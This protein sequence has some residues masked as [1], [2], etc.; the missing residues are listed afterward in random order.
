MPVYPYIPNSVPEIRDEMLSEIGVPDIESLYREIPAAL[1]LGRPLDLPPA[2][3]SEYDLKKHVEALLAENTTC[4]EYVSFL[5]AGCYRHFV[6]AVCD[7]INARGEFLTAYAG[8]TYSDHGKHQAWFEFQSLLAEL[9][10]MDVVGFPTYDWATAAS[11]AAL[12]ACRLTGR[13]EVLVPRNLGPGTA[14]SHAQL[15]QGSG[16]GRSR[17]ATTRTQGNWTWTTCGSKLSPQTA[18]V[19]FENPTCFGLI[20][21]RGDEISQIADDA[22]ALSLVGVDPITLGLLAPPS[23]YGA[24]LVCGDVQPLGIHMQAGGGL[25]GFIAS[26]DDQRV[27]A[28]YP[29]LLETIGSDRARRGMGVRLGHART[30]ILRPARPGQGLHR[31]VHR[32]VGDHRRRL[33]GADGTTGHG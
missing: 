25:C 11:S 9:V 6:P 13:R 30:D 29:T 28:E 17:S 10:D 3:T 2:Y 18:A 5:G 8:A 21:A 12:M 15:H 32:V 27:M 24:D 1:R 7:E 26:R 22:G 31:H 4:E 20:E 14:L 23:T 16:E 19:Y 33:P